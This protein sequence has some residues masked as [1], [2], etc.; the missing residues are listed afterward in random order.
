[1]L[2]FKTTFFLVLR[3][4]FLS[5][6]AVDPFYFPLISTLSKVFQA[7]SFGFEKIVLFK[8]ITKLE[9]NTPFLHCCVGKNRRYT[10]HTYPGERT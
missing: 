2:L 10:S 1:M 6:C 8:I 3:L 4:S 5:S 9:N 7:F